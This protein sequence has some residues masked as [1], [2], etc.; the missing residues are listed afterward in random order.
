M[1]EV[2]FEELRAGG[3]RSPFRLREPVSSLYESLSQMWR[4]GEQVSLPTLALLSG[5]ITTWNRCGGPGALGAQLQPARWPV[6]QLGEGL[7]LVVPTRLEISALQCVMHHP[8]AD[9]EDG[10]AAIRRNHHNRE[11]MT[12]DPQPDWWM[13]VNP[14][15]QLRLLHTQAGFYANALAP[16]ECV[17]QWSHGL[18][19]S[20]L[21]LQVVGGGIE[22]LFF[23]TAQKVF[24]ET[25][26]VLELHRWP[27]HQRVFDFLAGREVLVISPLA[28]QVE[29]QH[30]SGKA[31]ALFQD[32]SIQPYGL[33]CLPAP[34]SL[35]PNR[36]HTGFGES[37]QQCLDGID[38]IYQQLPFSVLMVAGGAYSLPICDAVQAR[39]GVSCLRH[40]ALIHGYFGISSE[41]TAGWRSGKR[42]SENW[43]H[44]PQLDR[45]IGKG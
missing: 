23:A 31:F 42:H 38:R 22:P 10:L 11:W 33:R 18:F 44:G 1:I 43:M 20:L 13:A 14:E 34:D 21:N 6:A 3:E 8:A 2:F 5:A 37:L 35:W 4:T 29:A 36:P 30:R 7:S 41:A 9:I 32:L 17:N 45:W 40:D 16:M 39:Y 15:D 27:D 12:R 28:E 25:G 26:R 24:E 19:S